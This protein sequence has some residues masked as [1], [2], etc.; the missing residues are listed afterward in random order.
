[1]LRL[2]CSLNKKNMNKESFTRL[3]AEMRNAEKNYWA[4][5][6][7]NELIKSLSLEKRVDEEIKRVADL[8][9]D[10]PEKQPDK[11]STHWQFFCFVTCLRDATKKY[12]EYKKRNR[13][14]NNADQDVLKDLFTSVKHYEAETDK[15]LQRLSDQEKRARGIIITYEVIRSRPRMHEP[16]VMLSTQDEQLANVE[17]YD[18]NNKSRDGSI[19]SIRRTEKQTH[20]S[21]SQQNPI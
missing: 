1:M 18:L 11:K 15:H 16:Q 9:H 3:V 10:H 12:F 17:C 14:D 6:D 20:T 19:Y 4:R 7:H 2:R 13:A 21:Q 5:R 8:L